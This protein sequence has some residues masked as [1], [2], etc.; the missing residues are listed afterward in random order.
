[1]RAY[2]IA[3]RIRE[4]RLKV[5]LTQEDLAE[6]TGIARP[7]IARLERGAHAPSTAT[8]QRISEALQVRMATLV[9]PASHDVGMENRKLAEAGIG[10]WKRMLDRED[11]RRR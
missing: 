1:V 10:E 8:I 2:A 4:A 3:Q 5:G 7:N 6:R 9:D 11:K